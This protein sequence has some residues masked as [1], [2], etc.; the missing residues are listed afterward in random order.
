MKKIFVSLMV[1]GVI[2]AVFGTASSVSAKGFTQ[3]PVL[4][5]GGWGQGGM[6]GV[7]PAV[8]NEAVH[9]L[10]MEAYATE[11]GISVEDLN[12]RT[13]AGER[14]SQIALST[15]LT[16]EE[17]WTLKTEVHASVVEQALAEGLITQAQ[18][19]LMLQ[20]GSRQ[21]NGGMGNGNRGTGMYAGANC[22]NLTQV[23][24]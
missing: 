1:I 9:D 14:L 23:T 15:G 2:V 6:K 18:A 24:P 8:E 12:A 4:D 11:L 22:P 20:A 19:D 10:M 16:I 13:E 17:F 7:G 21:M 5:Q 3:Q